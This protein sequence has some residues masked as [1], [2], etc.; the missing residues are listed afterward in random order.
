[1]PEQ[2]VT[3]EGIFVTPELVLDYTL[4]LSGLVGEVRDGAIHIRRAP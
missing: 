3:L 1:M 4:R 2:F